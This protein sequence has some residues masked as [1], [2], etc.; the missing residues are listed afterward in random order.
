MFYSLQGFWRQSLALRPRQASN[1]TY[2]SLR[3]QASTSLV[4]FSSVSTH[5]YWT[6][7]IVPSGEPLP[8]GLGGSFWFSGLLK[9]LLS[10]C[11]LVSLVVRVTRSLQAHMYQ[12]VTS[13]NADFLEFCTTPGSPELLL[14]CPHRPL[15]L[16]GGGTF[17]QEIPFRTE[18]SRAPLLSEHC[19]VVAL[20]VPIYCKKSNVLDIY[21]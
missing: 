5:F 11:S 8:S 18:C 19:P 3:L 13:G 7:L 14:S 9:S 6:P 21:E 17:A 16:R 12:S 4:N 20:L 2:L 1:P 10:L 15:S